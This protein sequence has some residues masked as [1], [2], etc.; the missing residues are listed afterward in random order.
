[1]SDE[2]HAEELER[3]RSVAALPSDVNRLLFCR[4]LP[5]KVTSL[6]VYQLFEKFGPVYRVWLGK[7]SGTRGTAYVMFASVLDA[8]QAVAKL[9]NLKIGSRHLSVVFFNKT[10]LERSTLARQRKSEVLEKQA[11]AFAN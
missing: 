8:K 10:K 5:F 2:S 11:E 3:Y 6:Q 1:M 4:N 7:E 9:N